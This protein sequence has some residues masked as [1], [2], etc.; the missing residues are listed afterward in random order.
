MGLQF[1]NRSFGWFLGHVKFLLIDTPALTNP[2]SPQ[3]C[4]QYYFGLVTPIH[5]HGWSPPIKKKTLLENPIFSVV[6]NKSGSDASDLMVQSQWRR[7]LI[8]TSIHMYIY[9]YIILLLYIAQNPQNLGRTQNL[10]FNKMHFPCY[11]LVRQ[12]HFE[13]LLKGTPFWVGRPPK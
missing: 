6:R 4:W 5:Q 8:A 11:F 7:Y 9:I 12:R 2:H 1:W 13:K 10:R 3:N